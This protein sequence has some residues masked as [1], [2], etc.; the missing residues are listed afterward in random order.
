MPS[1]IIVKKNFGDDVQNFYH[2][3]VFAR[4]RTIHIEI[5]K[6]RTGDSYN[7]EV[8]LNNIEE[9]RNRKYRF[10]ETLLN[11]DA[12]NFNETWRRFMDRQMNK[13]YCYIY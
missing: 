8:L 10:A 5:A 9:L 3:E 1:L 12:T 7:E 13:T 4:L 6:I 2:N 11:C